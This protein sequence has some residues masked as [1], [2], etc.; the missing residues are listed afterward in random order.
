LRF[1]RTQTGDACAG[2]ACSHVAFRLGEAFFA[3]RF[4]QLVVIPVIDVNADDDGALRFESFLHHRD[5][6]PEI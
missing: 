6:L 4:E 3:D 5:D 1:V 2:A